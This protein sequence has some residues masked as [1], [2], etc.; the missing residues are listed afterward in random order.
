MTTFVYVRFFACKYL[1]QTRTHV[2]LEHRSEYSL[3]LVEKWDRTR[4]KVTLW[5]PFFDERL[6]PR[7]S[8]AFESYRTHFPYVPCIIYSQLRQRKNITTYRFLITARSVWPA[9][10]SCYWSSNLGIAALSS[11][12]SLPRTS[13]ITKSVRAFS[14]CENHW[15]FAAGINS[16]TTNTHV[17]TYTCIHTCTRHYLREN[18]CRVR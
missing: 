17:C 2:A 8:A 6:F 11:F 7:W 18:Q 4:H 14:N 1:P 15:Y 9:A 5:F 16:R 3:R 12:L 10:T 13:I